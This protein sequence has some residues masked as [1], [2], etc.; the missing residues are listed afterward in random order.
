MQTESL[1][2]ELKRTLPQ[3]ETSSHESDLYI[4]AE[5]AT[6]AQVRR[7]ILKHQHT[8]A[9]FWADDG[10]GHW[11]EVPFA[12]DPFWEKVAARIAGR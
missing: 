1:Y 10:S 5:P 3:V 7:L 2:A 4:K 11:Y 9:M 6:V 12:F 8:P